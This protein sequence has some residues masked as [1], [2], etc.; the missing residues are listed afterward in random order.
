[1]S[2]REVYLAVN[3]HDFNSQ[4]KMIEYVYYIPYERYVRKHP[5]KFIPLREY[6]REYFR[7]KL[8]G[9]NMTHLF[10]FISNNSRR[11]REVLLQSVANKYNERKNGNYKAEVDRSYTLL[12]SMYNPSTA[13]S[14]TTANTNPPVVITVE[15]VF[16]LTALWDHNYHHFLLDSVVKLI[17]YLPFLLKYPD[18]K[19]HIRRFEQFCKKEKYISGGIEI[20]RRIWDILGLIARPVGQDPHSKLQDIDINKRIISGILMHINYIVIYVYIYMCMYTCVYIYKQ[21]E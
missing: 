5:G 13:L 19:I 16:V 21:V 18:I 12:N 14:T 8:C 7:Q 17:R 3:S 2:V 15:K 4:K 1:M 6:I 20:R 11:D 9:L 10:E